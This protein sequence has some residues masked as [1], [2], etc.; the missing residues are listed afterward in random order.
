MDEDFT[1]KDLEYIENSF[2]L[3]DKKYLRWI[4][5]IEIKKLTKDDIENFQQRQKKNIIKL[6]CKILEKR[7]DKKK[8]IF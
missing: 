7:K 6:K 8:L 1:K 5:Q 3:Q 2:N 4:K